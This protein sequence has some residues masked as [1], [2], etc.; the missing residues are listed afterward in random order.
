MLLS[1]YYKI[2]NNAGLSG[3]AEL[4]QRKG[5]YVMN[6]LDWLTKGKISVIGRRILIG[7]ACTVIGS[8]AGASLAINTKEV[9][10]ANIDVDDELKTDG[11]VLMRCIPANDNE[12]FFKVVIPSSGWLTV[13]AKGSGDQK[14][15]YFGV[16]VNGEEQL[17]IGDLNEPSWDYLTYEGSTFTAAVEKGTCYVK[18]QRKIDWWRDK[19][20]YTLNASFTPVENTEKEPNDNFAEAMPLPEKQVVDGFITKESPEDY[21]KVELSQESAVK[22][23]FSANDDFVCYIL[24]TSEEPGPAI[25]CCGTENQEKSDILETKLKKGTSYLKVK[26][27]GYGYA[28]GAYKLNWE[29]VPVKITAI[30][31]TGPQNL[32]LG[33]TAN[34]TATIAPDNATNK[35]ISWSSSDA[36]IVKVDENGKVTAQNVGEAVVYATSNDGSKVYGMLKLKVETIPVSKISLTGEKTLRVG[37]SIKL[38]ASVSPADANNKKL[39]WSS[40]DK[41]IASV[42]ANG[43]VTAKKVGKVTIKASAQDGSKAYGTIK[44]TVKAAEKPKKIESVKT[45]DLGNRKIKIS[46]KKQS[47]AKKYEIQIA[48]NKKFTKNLITKKAASSKSNLTVKYKKNGTVYVRVRGLNKDGKAGTWSEIKSLKVK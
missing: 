38:K 33:K 35:T 36:S 37:N 2:I 12:D 24:D 10:A 19:Y 45:K 22:I 18:V 9:K 25:Y 28:T 26:A 5:A 13:S 41:S 4:F 29:M 47:I 20:D 46:W 34:L 48:T 32:K 6:T 16:L 44:I 15:G 31:V 1:E 40:S 39:K 23:S 30:T 21:Y 11:T 7:I 8:T 27:N 42:D 14:L 17:P 43:K 3:S